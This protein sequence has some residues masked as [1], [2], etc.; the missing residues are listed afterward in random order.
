MTLDIQTNI[1][2]LRKK[3]KKI[4]EIDESVKKLAS[5]MIETMNANQGIGLAAPQVQHLQR[6]IIVK[7]NNKDLVFI[8][9]KIIWKSKEKEP[10]DEGCLS[11]PGEIITI[12]RP[13]EIKIEALNLSGEKVKATFKNLSAKIFQHELDHLNGVLITDHVSLKERIKKVFSK[14]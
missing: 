9:P 6:I 10:L 5:D 4:G 3:S 1:R 2:F 8:N 11:V 14:K 13:K 7:D 12:W